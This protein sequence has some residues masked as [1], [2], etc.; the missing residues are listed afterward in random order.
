MS[1]RAFKQ[2]WSGY[3]LTSPSVAVNSSSAYASWNGAT[4]V[5]SWILLGG[6]NE[7]A[8]TTQLANTT[9][10]G[11][12]TQLGNV[13]SSYPFLAV[14]ALGSDVSSLNVFRPCRAPLTLD[15]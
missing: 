7:S 10:T 11:F 15:I 2:A 9:K 13:N 8:V 6:T 12:E 3:P 4:D 14:A 1:Y 5:T